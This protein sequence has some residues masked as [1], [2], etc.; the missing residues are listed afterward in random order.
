M[1]VN[2]Y[3][4]HPAEISAVLRTAR[5]RFPGRRVLAAFQPH[6]HRRTLQLLPQFAESLARADLCLVSDIYGA[7]ESLEMKAR[8]SSRQLVEELRGCGTTAESTGEVGQLPERLRS[9]YHP[10]DVV[11]LLGAGDIDT[12]LEDVL[13][14]L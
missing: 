8:I 13:A 3:A 2:D 4:H 6:Q 1:L 14:F 9:I 7:R 5:R 11:L 10:G 12:V